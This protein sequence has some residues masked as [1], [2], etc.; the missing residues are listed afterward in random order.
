M[1]K[2]SK[3]S[4]IRTVVDGITFAS[5][6]EAVRYREL[7]LLQRTGKIY[8]LKLQP[9]FVCIVK[10]K[11]VCVYIA[12]FQYHDYGL[13]EIGPPIKHIEDVKGVRTPV[14]KLKKKLVEALYDIVIEE[15]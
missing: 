7:K 15:V 6:R 4:N 12:D 3:Y 10:G 13:N 9:Q 14:Y 11:K 1:A 8:Q 5:K 2:P